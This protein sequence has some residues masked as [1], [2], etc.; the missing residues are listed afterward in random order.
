[1]PVILASFLFSYFHIVLVLSRFISEVHG[2]VGVQQ[3][4]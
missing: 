2:R 1:V 4:R 3:A